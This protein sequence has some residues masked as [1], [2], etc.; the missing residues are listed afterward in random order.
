MGLFTWLKGSL[1]GAEVL[2]DVYHRLGKRH[3]FRETHFVD[4]KIKDYS[5]RWDRMAH[6]VIADDSDDHRQKTGYMSYD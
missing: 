2:T 4:P 5:K 1:L 6:V 3:A